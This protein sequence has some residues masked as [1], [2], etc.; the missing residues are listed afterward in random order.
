MST[1]EKPMTSATLN[2]G[3]RTRTV[4][5]FTVLATCAAIGAVGG[6][7]AASPDEPALTVRYSDLNLSTRQGALVL[8]RRI[9]VAA[10]QVCAADNIINLDAV[11]TAR[12]C[13]EEV[14]AR[15]V[16]DVNR[17]MLASVYAERQ[18]RGSALNE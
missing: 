1:Q 7:A 14:I 17:P 16:R 2:P 4:V 11:A 10:Y 6:A 3:G 8:Y 18:G 15:A 12:V 5:A 9:A 13:R